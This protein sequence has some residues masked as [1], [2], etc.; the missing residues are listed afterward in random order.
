MQ[1][2][3]ELWLNEVTA[4]QTVFRVTLQVMFLTMLSTHPRKDA[5]L[6]G[7][8]DQVMA[9][10]NRVNKT[11]GN[12]HGEQKHK[13][14]ALMRAELFFQETQEALG[15]SDPLAGGPKAAS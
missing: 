11:E 4:D 13:Q 15:I 1:E 3:I 5:M 9:A 8:K 6:L 10:L 7:L 14:L 2:Q 12:A